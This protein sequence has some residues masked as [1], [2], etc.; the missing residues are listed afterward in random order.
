VLLS[1]LDLLRDLFD[2]GILA[3]TSVDVVSKAGSALA[4]ST[5]DHPESV[6]MFGLLRAMRD[7]DVARALGFLVRFA[8]HFGRTLAPPDKALATATGAPALPARR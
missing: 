3:H 4:A 6:G 1:K 8:R 7:P 5:V 2:S